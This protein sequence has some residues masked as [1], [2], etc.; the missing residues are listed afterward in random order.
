MHV[1]TNKSAAPRFTQQSIGQQSKVIADTGSVYAL[2][3]H[4]IYNFLAACI[5]DLL[6]VVSLNKLELVTHCKYQHIEKLFCSRLDRQMMLITS[7]AAQCL[8]AIR[9]RALE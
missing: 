2:T 5:L 4:C 9:P 8:R 3:F 6:H 1:S 7:A